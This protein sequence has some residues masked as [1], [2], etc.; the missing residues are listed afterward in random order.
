MPRLLF[1]EGQRLR[2]REEPPLRPISWK[3]ARPRR[4]IV[5]LPPLLPAR[6]RPVCGRSEC[7]LFLVRGI[8]VRGKK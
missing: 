2:P 8:E 3:N 4:A 1:G 7:L 5:V 6:L